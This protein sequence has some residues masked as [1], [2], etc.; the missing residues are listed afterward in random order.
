ML[1]CRQQ[2]SK[3][4]RYR[5]QRNSQNPSGKLQVPLHHDNASEYSHLWITITLQD[6]PDFQHLDFHLLQPVLYLL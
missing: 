2:S 1:R 3:Y 6:D 5:N 4:S